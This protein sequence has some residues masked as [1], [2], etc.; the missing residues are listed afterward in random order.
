MHSALAGLT[1]SASLCLSP[2]LPLPQVTC[3][4]A[5]EPLLLRTLP[6]PGQGP[7]QLQ[8]C[9]GRQFRPSSPAPCGP[10]CLQTSAPA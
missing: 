3:Q 8:T 5:A 4:T 9:V 1:H 6:K 2:L 7:R 10:P